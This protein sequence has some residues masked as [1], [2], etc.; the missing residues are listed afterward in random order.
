M[1]W[2][3]EGMEETD[4]SNEAASGDS[5]DS[6][7]TGEIVNKENWITSFESKAAGLPNLPTHRGQL[8]K[9]RN[10]QPK[11]ISRMYGTFNCQFCLK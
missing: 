4:E 1:N 11:Q 3:I 9:C 5:Q 8:E 10:V 6:I 2:A 7:W